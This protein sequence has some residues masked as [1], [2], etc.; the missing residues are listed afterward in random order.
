[1]ILATFQ[2]VQSRKLYAYKCN[3]HK[4]R[5]CNPKLMNDEPLKVLEGCFYTFPTPEISPSLN[6]DVSSSAKESLGA[7]FYWVWS[8]ITCH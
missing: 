3:N 5:F 4:K 8:C 1:M 2:N 6:M 7:V